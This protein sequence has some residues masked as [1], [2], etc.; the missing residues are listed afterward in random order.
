MVPISRTRQ[1]PFFGKALVLSKPLEVEGGKG[2]GH[3][4]LS[5]HLVIRVRTHRGTAKVRGERP[6][7]IVEASFMH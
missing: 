2:G 5:S 6:G 3:R 4:G 7:M 1:A